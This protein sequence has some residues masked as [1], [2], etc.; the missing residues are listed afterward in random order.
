MLIFGLCCVQNYAIITKS[1]SSDSIYQLGKW[2][3]WEQK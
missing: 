3:K 1:E 2:V